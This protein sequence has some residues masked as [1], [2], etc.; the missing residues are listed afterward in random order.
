MAWIGFSVTPTV[1]QRQ[2]VPAVLTWG[3][4]R[5]CWKSLDC[6]PG[7]DHVAAILDQA[8]PCRDCP[9]SMRGYA[10]A[11]PPY[12]RRPRADSSGGA[13]GGPLR[14]GAGVP[15][16]SP[17]TCTVKCRRARKF[18]PFL[19]QVPSGIMACI[20]FY[21][22]LTVQRQVVPAVLTR[23][24]HRHC[25]KSLDCLPGKDHAAAILDQALPCRDCPR[26]TRGYASASP[27]YPRRPRADS[28]G[29]AW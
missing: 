13:W 14:R 6:L 28:S 7:K 16:T 23:G 2:V 5:H 11:S 25:W 18:L 24:P 3:P 20:G 10:S 21:V 4:H 26:S 17:G 8:L 27:P 15:E 1:V 12:P 9:R 22:T 19:P 29:G